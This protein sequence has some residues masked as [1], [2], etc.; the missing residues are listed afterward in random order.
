MDFFVETPEEKVEISE[1]EGLRITGVLEKLI[2]EGAQHGVSMVALKNARISR[3]MLVHLSKNGNKLAGYILNEINL[4]AIL[5]EAKN[6]DTKE[7]VA[8]EMLS[9]LV[10]SEIPNIR[11]RAIHLLLK[12]NADKLMES[13]NDSRVQA[14]LRS[15][16]FDDIVSDEETSLRVMLRILRQAGTPQAIKEKIVQ[17]IARIRKIIEENSAQIIDWN[18]KMDDLEKRKR[19]KFHTIEKYHS[20]VMASLDEFKTIPNFVMDLKFDVELAFENLKP[21]V[22]PHEQPTD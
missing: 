13:L 19:V 10:V 9:R 14:S 22:K 11:R 3:A 7:D 5:E 2:Q 17:R 8:I 18:H 6:P 1:G 20:E 15:D 21:T 16:I 4:R 12:I